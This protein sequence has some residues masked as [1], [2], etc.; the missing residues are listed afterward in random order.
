MI[1]LQMRC[2]IKAIQQKNLR[3]I[4]IMNLAQTSYSSPTKEMIFNSTVVCVTNQRQ[5]ERLIKAGR[6]IA[7]IAK[8]PLTVISVVNPKSAHNDTD[9]LEYL[10]D[11]SKQNNAVMAL[12][13]S[14]NPL[15]CI[16]DFIRENKAKNVVTGMRE[17][18]NSILTKL[19]TSF[20]DATFFTVTMDGEVLRNDAAAPVLHL[21]N[22]IAEREE[23]LQCR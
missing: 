18:E 9:A 22:A 20:K 14:T 17:G 3:G 11:V 5:C 6:V 23:A 10:F 7:N 8:T 2:I 13:Y 21:N 16:E 1:Y 12:Q 4:F 15:A 19:W